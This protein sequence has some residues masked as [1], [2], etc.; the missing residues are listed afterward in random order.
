MNAPHPHDPH[1]RSG[2][3]GIPSESGSGFFGRYPAYTRR[4]LAQLE[5][6]LA[7]LARPD[8]VPMQSI[9]VA[10]PTDRIPVAEAPQLVF[11]PAVPGDLFEGRW[12]TY[13]FRIT[14]AAPAHWAGSPVELAWDSESEATVWL[15]DMPIGACNDAGVDHPPRP[16]LRLPPTAMDGGAWHLLVEMACNH[17]YGLPR[18]A[19]APLR[20]RFELRRCELVRVD[21]EAWDLWHDY[22]VLAQLCDEHEP[23]QRSRAFINKTTMNRPGIDPA[24]AGRLLGELNRFANQLDPTDRRTWQPARRILTELLASH[25]G[26]CAHEAS[27]VAHAHIDTVWLWPLE[28]THRKCVRTFSN[29][30]GLM[31][32]YPDLIF[33]CSQAYQYDVIRQSHPGLFQRM[34]NQA[35]RGGW[36][37]VGG[38]WVEPDCNVPSGESLCRQFLYGQRFFEQHFGA[39]SDIFW[40][41]DVFGYPG[42]LP[43]IMRH[44]G[45]QRFLTQKLSWN[46]F[47]PPLHHTFLWRGID[48]SDV[49]THFPPADTY[50]GSFTVEELRYH[51]ANYKD[52]D[53]SHHAIYLFGHG[54]GGGGATT[55]MLESM[56]RLR[57]L[58]G[59]P[60]CT[61]RSP[62]AFFEALESTIDSIPVIDGELYFELHRGTL[63][64]HAA[65]KAANR[66]CEALLQDLDFIVIGALLADASQLPERPRIDD[67]W[68]TVCLH[69]F[70]DDL[71]GTSITEVYELT[72]RDL[73]AVQRDASKLCVETLEGWL[74]PADAGEHGWLN[75]TSVRRTDV[76]EQGD[77]LMVVQS[78]PFSS[79]SK[80]G[81]AVPVTMRALPS[82]GYRLGNGFLQAEISASG[83]ITSLT[84]CEDGRNVL[85]DGGV[86]WVL[87]DD[88][89]TMWEA[90]DIDPQALETAGAINTDARIS[91]TLEHNARCELRI[92]R[93][94]GHES[95]MSIRVRLDADA[96]SLELHHSIDWRERR[97]CLRMLASS[98]FTRP[99][100]SY[101][102]QYGAIERPTTMNN[103][104]EI[105]QYEVP[106]QRWADLAAPDAGLA[107]INDA[108]YGCSAHGRHMSVTLLRGTTD[109]DPTADIGLHAFSLSLMPHAGCWRSAGVVDEAIRR[110]RPLLDVPGITDFQ[111]PILL[112]EREGG[113]IVDTV[114]RAQDTDDIVVRMYEAHGAHASI[115]LQPGAPVTAWC[116]SN[117][118]EDDLGPL[119]GNDD[120][121][122]TLELRPY[123]LRTIIGRRSG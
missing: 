110:N 84:T 10:G 33:A 42:Q 39:R 29:A 24:W 122:I 68:R 72:T 113:A 52:A 80:T 78:D 79:A 54:D 95:T 93:S 77:A 13:W 74:G 101:E 11:A 25:N 15:D 76:V 31:E 96:K 67:L 106:A 109:P 94:F 100:A 7:A 83:H 123:Q 50:N 73:E 63:T 92:E 9:E 85:G 118:L 30:V 2:E 5:H 89:P 28:E 66:R 37:P 82:G 26:T 43:Q 91:V 102:I 116:E 32:R 35:A 40:N 12:S 112:R 3:P 103:T 21:Q 45:I 16:Y 59:V 1:A 75:T 14:G 47:N 57:D 107:I 55:D 88:Q 117:A 70:H 108:K 60:R 51:T 38:T 6:T 62:E 111:P 46:A 44:G 87:L 114:K 19:D 99:R 86:R 121:S 56:T 115:T 48:G 58:Q 104:V 65:V 119:V 17:D 8:A 71:P 4:R 22:R 61:P 27:V 97:R 90:W 49:L 98:N 41:P 105:A 18:G 53:R 20:Q 64:T 34:R 120:G 81:A 69:Q 36:A 23:E